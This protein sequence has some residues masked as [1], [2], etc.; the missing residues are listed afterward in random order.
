MT[1]STRSFLD[2]VV[3]HFHICNGARP[4]VG[5]TSLDGGDRPPGFY[6]YEAWPVR[7]MV[8]DHVVRSVEGPQA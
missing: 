8:L 3:P 7:E 2:V 1:V 5:E 4:V 6:Q